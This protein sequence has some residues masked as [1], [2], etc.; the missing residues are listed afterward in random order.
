MGRFIINEYIEV[1]DPAMACMH[2]DLPVGIESFL[3][4]NAAPC[5]VTQ[6]Q[7]ALKI[8]RGRR[9]CV[10]RLYSFSA[11]FLM[12]KQKQSAANAIFSNANIV[13]ICLI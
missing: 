9:T 4:M 7:L 3:R 11:P 13:T 5:Q 6:D 12:E 2:Q 10:F 8:R 1:A